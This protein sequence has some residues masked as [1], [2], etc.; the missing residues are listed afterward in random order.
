M[1]GHENIPVR[2]VGIIMSNDAF[3]VEQIHQVAKIC[4]M[5]PKNIQYQSENGTVYSMENIGY[6]S[7]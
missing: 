5:D 6:T 1:D 4:W 3:F 2:H 7:A